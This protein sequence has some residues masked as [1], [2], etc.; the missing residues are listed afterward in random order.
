MKKLNV[1]IL[2]LIFLLGYSVYGQNQESK[3][4]KLV[5]L[6]LIDS[7]QAQVMSEMLSYEERNSNAQLIY[8]LFQVVYQRA[9]GDLYST[10][11]LM[12]FDFREPNDKKQQ[13]KHPQIRTV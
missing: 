9:T 11:L 12:N 6:K 2:A 5:D 10:E 1:Y 8:A 13:C 7:G 3:I 4:Q